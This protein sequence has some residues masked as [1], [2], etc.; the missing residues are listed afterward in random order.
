LIAAPVIKP[1]DGILW[2]VAHPPPP[3]FPAEAVKTSL[4]IGLNYLV[5]FGASS[6]I[7]ILH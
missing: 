2:Q 1:P 4:I 6:L 5:A 7:K 3:D